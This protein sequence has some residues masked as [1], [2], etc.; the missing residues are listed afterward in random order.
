MCGARRR[1]ILPG[2]T[3]ERKSGLLE[4]GW[5]FHL[6]WVL[7]PRLAF[8][9]WELKG[10]ATALPGR[11]TLG[12]AFISSFNIKGVTEDRQL[13]TWPQGSTPVQTVIK[14]LEVEEKSRNSV[15]EAQQMA[16]WEIPFLTVPLII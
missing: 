14:Y 13:C 12:S 4:H 2:G 9:T 5:L 6:P 3:G 15:L 10:W 7:T 8:Y 16:F 1:G 11:G